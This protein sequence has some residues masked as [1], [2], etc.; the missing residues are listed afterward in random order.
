MF[1][2]V[3]G[4]EELVLACSCV[5]CLAKAHTKDYDRLQVAKCFYEPCFAAEYMSYDTD[6]T[7]ENRQPMYIPHHPAFNYSNESCIIPHGRCSY[8]YANNLL[9]SG[10][11]TTL[12]AENETAWSCWTED[13]YNFLRVVQL[14]THDLEFLYN[15]LKAQKKRPDTVT[16]FKEIAWHLLDLTREYQHYEHKIVNSAPFSEALLKVM[17]AV[18]DK[19]PFTLS[20]PRHGCKTRV[21]HLVHLIPKQLRSRFEEPIPFLAAYE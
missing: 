7:S 1:K 19:L 20:D 14:E 5:S 13:D 8:V 18:P 9:R 6:Q 10:A 12:R 11:M 16:K 15:Y 21:Q 3:R 2:R 4:F 17:L